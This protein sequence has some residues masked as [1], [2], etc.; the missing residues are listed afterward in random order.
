MAMFRPPPDE[1]NGT[2]T[3]AQMPPP[4]PTAPWMPD[5]AIVLIPDIDGYFRDCDCTG[6]SIGGLER[7]P[8]AANSAPTL[9]VV[10]YGDTLFPPQGNAAGVNR[11]R[12]AVE[13][14]I[15]STARLWADL[16]NVSWHPSPS[17]LA[18]L[19]HH[20]VELGPLQQFVTT[21]A[22]YS[23]YGVTVRFGSEQRHLTLETPAA[24]HTLGAPTRRARGREVVVVGAWT[25]IPQED[26]SRTEKEGAPV[27]SR[28]L[29]TV[30]MHR[31][32]AE[33]PVWQVMFQEFAKE[34]PLVSTWRVYVPASMPKSE[35]I[36]AALDGHE[37]RLAHGMRGTVVDSGDF[38]A[39]MHDS[40]R[41]CESCHA[42]AVSAWMESPH[43]KAWLTL[44]SRGQHNNP[45]CL[46]C[47]VEEPATFR[48]EGG[49]PLSAHFHRAAVTCNTCHTD[50]AKP[51][52][53]TC[54]GCH[55]EHTDPKGLY[56][57][58]FKT[59]CPGDK[60]YTQGGTSCPNR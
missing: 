48:N 25:T 43:A 37:L 52:L 20:G 44:T 30:A 55:N 53:A 49:M 10:F 13:Q 2:A 46:S 58:H 60:P 51:T 57:E 18:A 54:E 59:V 41:S 47:H 21:E 26:G 33:S 45:S 15:Q 6:A 35:A 16:G 9:H 22:E 7:I 11:S 38:L 17:D 19:A 34:S 56:R 29:G 3:A 28:T 42:Q 8:F 39:R 23:A 27:L 1:M 40:V 32:E 12:A 24:S 14:M 5:A 31:P 4:E 50:D 36:T